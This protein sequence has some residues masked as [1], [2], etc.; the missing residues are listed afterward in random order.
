MAE[1]KKST[2]KT[3][4]KA[5]AKK[6]VAKKPAAKKA[7]ATKDTSETRT[8]KAQK[9]A[10]LKAGATKA[11]A[12]AADT[13]GDF[14]DRALTKAK[15][16]ANQGKERTGI[17]IENLS[18]MIEDS[19]KTIDDNVGEKYGNYARSAADAVSSFATKLNAKEIDE[20]VEDARGFVRKSPAVAIGAAAVVGFLVSRL[21]KSGMD[22]DDA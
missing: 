10:P 12:T 9:A 13:T 2:A 3:P 11:A 7:T 21:I 22:D 17:A 1:V 4:A 15:S 8:T 6:P 18:R 19:A 16:A 5:A 20:M 14:K